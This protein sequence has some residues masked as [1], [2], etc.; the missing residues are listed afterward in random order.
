MT[1]QVTE[2]KPCPFCG[3]KAV[4]YNSDSQGGGVEINCTNEVCPMVVKSLYIYKSKKAAARAWNTRSIEDKLRS[5]LAV[6]VEALYKI[7]RPDLR[8]FRLGP[9]YSATIAKE[10]L[11]KIGAKN[12]DKK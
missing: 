12:V 5:D 2:L 6:A 9:E 7:T 10:A 11:A 8:G 3:S 4:Y 1:N